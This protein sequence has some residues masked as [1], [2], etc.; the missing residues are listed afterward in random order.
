MSNGG[1][2]LTVGNTADITGA[3]V[4]IDGSGLSFSAGDAVVL[5]DASGAG[6]LTGA[7]T[8]ITVSGGGYNW[9]LSVSGNKLIATVPEITG[10]ESHE[11]PILR[12]ISVGDGFLI[13]GI[14]PGETLSIYNTQG[15]QIYNSKSTATE[16]HVTL[17]EHGIYIIVSGGQAVKVVKR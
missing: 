7:P 6:T 14:V 1:T 12:V 11:S 4:S 17:R 9:S 3:T 15:Q 8:N 16:Q 5:I 2:V 10:I 13:T